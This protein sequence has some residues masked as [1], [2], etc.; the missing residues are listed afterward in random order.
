MKGFL[1]ALA[2]G[3]FITLQGVANTRIS[4]E[5]GTW[6]AAAMT[7]LTGFV[8]ALLLAL[9]LRSWQPSKLLEVKPIY[10]IG[11]A[12]G[13]FIIFGNVTAIQQ[14]GITLTTA[15]VLLGQLGLTF[16]IEWRG[17]IGV[18]KTRMGTMQVAGIILMAGGVMLLSI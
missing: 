16:L 6:Q 12:L 17:W 18:P 1:A 7:Q 13:A 15:L 9:L 5:L 2:A 8:G 3:F 14:V 10:G 4:G 11:G